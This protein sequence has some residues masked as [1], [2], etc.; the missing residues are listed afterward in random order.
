MLPSDGN[1]A[2]VGWKQPFCPTETKGHPRGQPLALYKNIML[3]QMP[4]NKGLFREIGS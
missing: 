1:T 3:L 4:I 2:S